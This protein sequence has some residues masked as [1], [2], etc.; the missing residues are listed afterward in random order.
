MRG[1]INVAKIRGVKRLSP[2]DFPKDIP[3][4]ISVI[5]DVLNAFFETVIN[6][7]RGKLTYADNFV[8][9]IKEF[10]FTHNTELEIS[11]SLNSLIGVHVVYCEALFQYA[12]RKID[13]STVGITIFYNAGAGTHTVKFILIG[14]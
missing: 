13:N 3:S 1:C 5:L 6:G 8:C 9:N 4:W 7:L 10:D 2:T 11:H 12:I 14:E